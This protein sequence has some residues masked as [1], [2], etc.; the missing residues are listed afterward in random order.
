MDLETL[1]ELLASLEKSAA[2]VQ[3]AID[4]GAELKLFEMPRFENTLT[5]EQVNRNWELARA[6][7]N[8]NSPPSQWRESMGPARRQLILRTLRSYPGLDL[9]VPVRGFLR[10]TADW[11]DEMRARSFNAEY[12]YR[13]TNIEKHIEADGREVHKRQAMPVLTKPDILART[14][15]ADQLRRTGTFGSIG[16]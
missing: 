11:S 4:E 3:K 14:A 12:V 5:A 9:R 10:I 15:E 1:R 6:Y 16:G 8:A 7:A 13:N 2:L